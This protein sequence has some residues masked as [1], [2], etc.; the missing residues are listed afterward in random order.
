[1]QSEKKIG[2]TQHP[3]NRSVMFDRNP[4]GIIY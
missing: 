3:I 2:L 1:M 4:G